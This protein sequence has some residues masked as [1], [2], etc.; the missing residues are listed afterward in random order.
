MS[1]SAIRIKTQSHSSHA[2]RSLADKFIYLINKP[3]YLINKPMHESTA[4]SVS[5][6][7]YAD[8]KYFS[9]GNNE[10]EKRDIS[11]PQANQAEQAI[12]TSNHKKSYI[13]DKQLPCLKEELMKLEAE[14]KG[15]GKLKAAYCNL[16]EFEAY[17]DYAMKSSEYHKLILGNMNKYA[18]IGMYAGS[19]YGAVMNDST[20]ASFAIYVGK[21][22][23][24][25]VIIGVAA[26][27][28]PLYSEFKK[29]KEECLGL[30]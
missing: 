3:I 15:K 9:L 11:K 29:V 27:L 7:H 10:P 1:G 12:N 16:R 18:K 21:F 22:I 2:L 8:L 23:S 6:I 14:K 13:D 26:S 25:G 30:K 5:I 17:S 19:I 20:L 24:F 4:T 28:P